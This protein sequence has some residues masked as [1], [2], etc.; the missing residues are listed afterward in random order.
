MRFQS[1]SA[2]AKA[3]PTVESVA[4][5]INEAVNIEWVLRSHDP[6]PQLGSNPLGGLQPKEYLKV[7]QRVDLEKL[8]SADD[9][10]AFLDILKDTALRVIS[11]DHSNAPQLWG[12]VLG[13]MEKYINKHGLI[14]PRDLDPDNGIDAI[15]TTVHGA[16]RKIFEIIRKL[17]RSAVAAETRENLDD[18]GLMAVSFLSKVCRKN[19]PDYFAQFEHKH[20]SGY[21]IPGKGDIVLIIARSARGEKSAKAAVDAIISLIREGGL[22][23]E[24][25]YVGISCL[26]LLDESHPELK[27]YTQTQVIEL[28]KDKTI[29]GDAALLAIRDL[30]CSKIQ[31]EV[32][33]TQ[34]SVDSQIRIISQFFSDMQSR[35]SSAAV[36]I[37]GTS[38]FLTLQMSQSR[39]SVVIPHKYDVH[40]QRALYDVSE[41]I[42]AI[43][44]ETGIALIG[45]FETWKQQQLS[46]SRML[47]ASTEFAATLAHG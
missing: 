28:L 12:D 29:Q 46:A 22:K 42:A 30:V 32:L 23:H 8:E 40:M 11:L 25:A 3:P 19:I 9:R 16:A 4:R 17:G 5:A 14:P 39:G 38:M 36:S 6:D 45:A 37:P 27:A 10:E 20:L 21:P 2:F 7:L 41:A 31:S 43:E 18:I 13:V 24:N 34:G 44:A 35:E 1:I 33:A 47:E 26:R 15:K